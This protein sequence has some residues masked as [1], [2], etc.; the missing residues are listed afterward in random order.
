VSRESLHTGAARPR[1]A[2]R[3]RTGRDRNTA[4]RTARWQRV[5]RARRRATRARS[6]VAAGSAAGARRFALDPR[7]GARAARDRAQQRRRRPNPASLVLLPVSERIEDHATQALATAGKLDTLVDRVRY[8]IA[9]ELVI[10]A[11]AID[12]R[13]TKIA[14]LGIG[15]Q[16]AYARVR[17]AVSVLDSDRPLGPD[18]ERMEAL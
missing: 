11:Q 8:L 1:G 2:P 13:G 16:R 3:A 6:V 17:E 18:F 4:S 14:S 10:A 12:L 5:V 9:I 15:P 7:R